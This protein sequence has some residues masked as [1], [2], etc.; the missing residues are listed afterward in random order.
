MFVMVADENEAA[1][2]KSLQVVVELY[3]KNVWHDARSVHCVSL[4]CFDV[5]T[6][7]KATALNFFLGT[8]TLEEEEEGADVDLTQIQHQHTINK[9]KK[10][11]RQQVA[12]A[13]ATVKR[14]E[15]KAAKVPHFNF[16]AL[17]L[18]HD[19]QGMLLF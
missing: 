5:R 7:I 14:A 9:K 6:K 1:A 3:K 2:K 15:A 10:S 16:S 11:H 19:P 12:K 13:V 18:L 4:A 17:Q 8:D